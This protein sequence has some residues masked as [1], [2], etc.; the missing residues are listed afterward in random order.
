MGVPVTAQRARALS[1]HTAMEVCTLGFLML[2]ASS[3]ITRSH[4]TLRRGA[5]A[6]TWEG[7]LGG[8]LPHK[9]K[10]KKAEDSTILNITL[11]KKVRGQGGGLAC[12]QVS[13]GQ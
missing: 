12:L 9:K 11:P 6:H 2:W 13:C 3:R 8:I 5:D 4:A 10:K 7:G 1:R